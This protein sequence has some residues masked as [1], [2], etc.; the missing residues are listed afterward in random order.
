[1]TDKKREMEAVASFI[2]GILP[3]MNTLDKDIVSQSNQLQPR[4]KDFISNLRKS[5][6]DIE[7]TTYVPPTAETMEAAASLIQRGVD[8]PEDKA[9]QIQQG[10]PGE[11]S[12]PLNPVVSQPNMVTPMQQVPQQQQVVVPMDNNQ[13]SL[14][15]QN[16]STLEGLNDN[17]NG[18][19]EQLKKI[20]KSLEII[21]KSHT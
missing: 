9:Q 2:K 17:L 10:A 16:H 13:L 11:V 1:M 21:A 14:P 19:F 7:N 5:V 6:K 12:R 8:I 18:I 4:T 3:E 20:A 15:F